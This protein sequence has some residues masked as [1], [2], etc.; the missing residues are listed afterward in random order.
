MKGKEK[1]NGMG[2]GL[3]NGMGRRLRRRRGRK[4]GRSSRLGGMTSEGNLG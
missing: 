1:R 4:M 3:R 2:R